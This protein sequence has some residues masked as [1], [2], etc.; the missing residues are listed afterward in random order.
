VSP[1]IPTYRLR[2]FSKTG[3]AD[4]TSA[5]YDVFFCGF[6]VCGSRIYNHVSRIRYETHLVLRPGDIHSDRP[7]DL[8][9]FSV[10]V[11]LVVR[12][13]VNKIPIP[14]LFKIVVRDATRY[15]LVIFTS[16][17]VL[18]VFLKFANVRISSQSSIFSLRSA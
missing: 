13:N 10:I 5:L 4:P 12:S 1:A 18:M 17:L 7:T 9:A 3:P 14:S 11:Y 15:F 16:H 8:L 6:V 2:C